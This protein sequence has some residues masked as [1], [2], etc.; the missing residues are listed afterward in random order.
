MDVRS[1]YAWS[2]LDNFEWSD[3][4]A[5]RFGLTYVDYDADQTR[6]AKDSSKWFARLADARDAHAH[7]RAT[8]DGILPADEDG[9]G[10]GENGDG[11]GVEEGVHQGQGGEKGGEGEPTGERERGGKGRGGRFWVELSLVVAAVIA[12]GAAVVVGK[13]GG[14]WG[15][16]TGEPRE[17]TRR[18]K[19]RYEGVQG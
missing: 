13:L 19:Q 8:A 2:I 6:T 16:G 1:Y 14:R 9:E 17:Q 7:W 3:G 12:V 4:Y 5:P 10:D 11:N 18:R 15:R